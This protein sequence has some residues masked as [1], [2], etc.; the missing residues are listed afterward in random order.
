M[1]ERQSEK[2]YPHPDRPGWMIDPSMSFRWSDLPKPTL[3][4]R[5]RGLPYT[6]PT[7]LWLWWLTRKRRK[8]GKLPESW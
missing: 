2:P 1:S 5:I 8:Q 3:R 7:R 4:Q 6:V